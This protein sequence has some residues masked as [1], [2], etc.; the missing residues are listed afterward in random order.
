MRVAVFL[1]LV[2]QTLTHPPLLPGL[3]TGYVETTQENLPV[4]TFTSTTYS[5][6]SH[7]GNSALTF[8]HLE[9]VYMGAKLVDLQFESCV[10]HGIGIGSCLF[11]LCTSRDP[12]ARL[13]RTWLELC[14]S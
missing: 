10:L 5:L 12:L 1:L 7:N 3:G 13:N 8:G 14:F 2:R 9:L 4:N 6:H 11:I